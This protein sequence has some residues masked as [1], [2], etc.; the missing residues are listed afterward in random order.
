MGTQASSV[1]AP[2]LSQSGTPPLRVKRRLRP[3]VSF[4]VTEH[5]AD[6]GLEASLPS[7]VWLLSTPFPRRHSATS[8]G[9]GLWVQMTLVPNQSFL[10]MDLRR[11]ES[12]CPPDPISSCSVPQEANTYGLPVG[13]GRW[14]AQLG[15]Q[16][17]GTVGVVEGRGGE[18]SR[19]RC[20]LQGLGCV[21]V[22][23][24]SPHPTTGQWLLAVSPRPSL[25]GPGGPAP[26][27]V[28]VPPALLGAAL[29]G[30]TVLAGPDSFPLC[31]YAPY[32]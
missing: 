11:V 1:W 5:A 32:L 3:R 4:R 14:E 23:L 8:Q 27:S 31:S 10:A 18:R 30:Y 16:R 26:T 25:V 17:A 13:L 24:L 29:P 21:S 15:N 7:P 19:Y 2:W 6:L 9:A 12:P 20:P 28:K 22:T